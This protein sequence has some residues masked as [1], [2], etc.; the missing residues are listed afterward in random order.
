[1]SF[2][3]IFNIAILL[4]LSAVASVAGAAEPREVRVG[5]YGNEPKIYLNAA[6]QPAG[7]FVDILDA[8]AAKARWKLVY[9]PCKWQE[10]LE[11][12]Q[13]GRIDLMPDVA[14][15]TQRD[16]TFSFHWTPVM[17]SWSQ[18]FTRKGERISSVLDLEGKRVALLRGSTQQENFAAMVSGFGIHVTLIEA[19][20]IEQA[21]AQVVAGEADAVITNNL[22]GE[23]KAEQYQLVETPIVF[24]PARLFYATAK[25]QNTELLAAID[26]YLDAWVDQPDSPYTRI[27]KKWRGKAPSPLIPLLA[28]QILGGLAVLLASVSVLAILLRRQV[29]LKTRHLEAEKAQVQAILDAMPDLLFEMSPDGVILSYHSARDDLLALPPELFLGKRTADVISPAAADVCQAAIAEANRVGVSIGRQYDLDIYGTP[30]CFEL[31]VAKKAL[32]SDEEPRFIV[33]SR[34]VTARK[35]AE[36]ALREFSE[37]LE[38]R[39]VERTRELALAKEA[40]EAANRTKSAFLANMSHEIRTPLNAITGM[41]H[42]MRRAGLPAEQGERLDKLEAAGE[43]LLEIINAV[44]DLSKIEAGRFALEESQVR[45]DAVIGNVAAMLRDRI[46]AKGLNLMTEIPSLPHQLLGDQ[47]RLQQALLNYAS[48]AVKFTERGSVALRARLVEED[49]DSAL[50]RFEVEDSGIGIDAA[51]VARLFSAFEQADNSITRKYGGTGLGLAITK[52]IAELTGGAAGVESTPG[53]GS[54]FWFT[55]RLRKAVETGEA[56]GGDDGGAA[57]QEIIARHAGKRILLAED[58]P[59]NRELTQVFLTDVRLRV[60]VAEDGAQALELAQRNDYDLILMDMQMPTMDGLTATR[61]IR[62]LP[63]GASVPILAMTANAFA[64]DKVRCFEAGMNDF[65]SKPV[66][67]AHFFALLLKWLAHGQADQR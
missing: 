42:L 15:S 45:V 44:L 10:C 63:N 3:K 61:A 14:Y 34:D 1:M 66:A 5:V 12:V 51:T 24:M 41:A 46:Y 22:S 47:T 31:S 9:V 52:K 62:Q 67:P 25:H 2:F 32:P 60:D 28:W 39:V 59:I 57:E 23:F 64:E 35:K 18:L 54:R 65:I 26:Q 30:Y 37:Q 38:L 55:T 58:E 33:I 21:F 17:L 13:A 53:V 56:P 49:G 48:N 7:I 11:A 43:H 27:L 19:E 20:S 29:K 4:G 16:Q 6:G 36:I 8:I 50:L 40:A